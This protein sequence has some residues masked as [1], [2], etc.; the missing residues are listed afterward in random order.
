MCTPTEGQRNVKTN[1]HAVTAVLLLP[2]VL[3]MLATALQ[4]LLAKLLLLEMALLLPP[5]RNVASK[6]IYCSCSC[7]RCMQVTHTVQPWMVLLMSL[8]RLPPTRMLRLHISLLLLPPF[9]FVCSCGQQSW[10]CKA[11]IRG[12]SR[13]VQAEK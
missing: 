11:E 2:S 7:Q 3:L 6:P 10:A 1:N 5:S 9:L 8:L 12:T 4:L 13:A